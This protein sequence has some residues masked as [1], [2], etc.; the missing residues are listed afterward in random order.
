MKCDD[1]TNFW[2]KPGGSGDGQKMSKPVSVAT[3]RKVTPKD[4]Q[5][6]SGAKQRSKVKFN[7]PETLPET[8]TGSDEESG[9]SDDTDDLEEMDCEE[10]ENKKSNCNEELQEHNDNDDAD[11]ADA[12]N[13]NANDDDNVNDDDNDADDQDDSD[14]AEDDTD[15]N[16][17]LD[18][19]GNDSCRDRRDEDQDDVVV[20]GVS[21]A[22][23]KAKKNAGC[24]M[25]TGPSTSGS[26]TRKE[27]S[28]KAQP[29]G[30]GKSSSAE[31]F[32]RQPPTASVKPAI[33]LFDKLQCH[34]K[35]NILQGMH[36]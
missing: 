24:G 29:A 7:V 2:R 28:S 25:K 18:E 20:T 1:G 27:K 9:K 26:M 14:D 6:Q 30:A 21:A 19:D 23:K 36:G 22:P 31:E 16:G 17:G 5:D 10:N 35:S 15:S 34:G 3:K 4:Q 8:W 12:N 32:E 13:A 11:D 33:P